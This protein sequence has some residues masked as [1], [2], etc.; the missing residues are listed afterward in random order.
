MGAWSPAYDLVVVCCPTGEV[1]TVAPDGSIR[2]GNV[3]YTWHGAECATWYQLWVNRNDEKFV[4][5]WFY[6]G[7]RTDL[8]ATRPAEMPVHPFGLFEWW[9]RGWYVDGFGPWSPGR[10]FH[11]GLARP[12]RAT[13]STLV[14]DDADSQEAEWYQLWVN[15]GGIAHWHQW[16]DTADTAVNGTERSFVLPVALPPGA[17]SWWIQTWKADG[18]GPWSEGLDF[19][20][21]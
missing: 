4:S 5:K 7:Q 1:V 15:R 13:A 8:L 17:Y 3:A 19:Q 10:T 21:P 12:L 16:V 18:L 14:W 11:Y 2:S 6:K 9:A 20:V